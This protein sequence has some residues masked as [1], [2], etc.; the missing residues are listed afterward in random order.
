MKNSIAL[1]TFIA[2][3]WMAAPEIAQAQKKSDT[4][5]DSHWLVKPG[6][7][8]LI[9]KDMSIRELIELLPEKQIEKVKGK[10]EFVGDE[11]DDYKIF[12]YKA[13]HL[14]TITP[15]KNADLASKIQSIQ[16]IDPRFKI[17]EGIG[18]NSTHAELK[19]KL[20][21]INYTPDTENIQ[22]NL[23]GNGTRFSIAK[24]ELKE[25]WWDED[26]MEIDRSKIPASAKITGF[27]IDWR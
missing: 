3:L 8:G 13:T 26:K 1:L 22:I 9:T 5:S 7:V 6:Q 16:I 23:K 27:V 15:E 17:E 10:G 14:L 20:L 19:A 2:A 25:G 24:S 4:K 21:V 11:Y 12:D 18:I